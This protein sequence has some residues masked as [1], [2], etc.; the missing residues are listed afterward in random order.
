MNGTG[1]GKVNERLLR[2]N[3]EAAW[4]LAQRALSDL[5]EWVEADRMRPRS[6]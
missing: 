1:Q 5:R 4:R 3:H 2:L 6:L